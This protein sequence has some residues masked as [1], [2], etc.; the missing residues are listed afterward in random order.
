M[1]SPNLP[2]T[3]AVVPRHTSRRGLPRPRMRR[4]AGILAILTGLLAALP[5]PA[6]GA[7]GEERVAWRAEGCR[8]AA[9]FA[10]TDYAAV[11]PLVRAPFDDNVLRLGVPGAETAT[12]IFTLNRCSDTTVVS[13]RG[14]F[15]TSQATEVIV[16]VML[17]GS[18]YSSDAFQ[19]Y[20]LVNYVDWEPLATAF[21]AIGLPTV[22]APRMSLAFPIDPLTRLGRIVLDVPAPG[23]HITAAGTMAAL[24]PPPTEGPATSFGVGP[25]G[26]VVV[27]HHSPVIGVNPAATATIMTDRPDGVV[28]TAMD[29][30]TREA[31]GVFFEKGPGHEHSATLMGELE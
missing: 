4:N 9:L 16:G 14:S 19:F 7:T 21:N 13:K 5:S 30:T 2:S 10:L 22:H 24:S 11:A 18:E 27:G 3:V 1:T 6:G 12:L 23:E 25:Q 26:V 15:T 28:G 8:E 20:T 31:H 17:S 29:A